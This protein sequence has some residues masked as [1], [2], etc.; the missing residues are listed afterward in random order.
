[1]F[2]PGVIVLGILLTYGRT[3]EAYM[4]ISNCNFRCMHDDRT[5]LANAIRGTIV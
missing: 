3:G 4:G 2:F 1:M 5:A